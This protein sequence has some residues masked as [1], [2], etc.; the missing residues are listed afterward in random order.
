MEAHVF[1]YWTVTMP[2]KKEALSGRQ[3]RIGGAVA[4]CPLRV[5]LALLLITPL[6]G[7]PDPTRPLRR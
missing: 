4:S 6:R 3:W 5:V 1:W 7:R 2:A